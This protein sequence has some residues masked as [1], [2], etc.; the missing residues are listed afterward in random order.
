MTKV[1]RNDPCPCG[2]GKKYKKCCINKGE[3]GS[4]SPVQAASSGMTPQQMAQTWMSAMAGQG[5]AAEEKYLTLILDRYLVDDESSK[6]SVEKLG[7][8]EDSTVIFTKNRQKIAEAV[9]SIEGEIVVTTVGAEQADE[10]R[11]LLT[12][13]NGIAFDSRTQDKFE[14]LD[15]ESKARVGAEMLTFKKRF[16]KVWV[17]EPNDRLGG[18]TPRQAVEDPE[19]KKTVV[20]LIK[21]LEKKEKKLPKNEQFSFTS[22]KKEL[23]L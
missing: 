10:I 20:P 12:S 14:K 18:K 3:N 5:E 7:K 19:L 2:S 8:V 21:E 9:L 22:V 23:G 13:I 1:G 6:K 11:E 17:D 4:F 15:A 16:F